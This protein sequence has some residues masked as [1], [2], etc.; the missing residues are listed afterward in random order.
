MVAWV[1]DVGRL[2]SPLFR[3]NETSHRAL[4]IKDAADSTASN[5]RAAQIARSHREFTAKIS[6]ALEEADEAVGFLELSH[7]EGILKGDEFLR[8]LDE[9]QQI[10]RILAKSRETAQSNEGK[11]RKGRKP[12]SRR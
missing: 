3:V 6:I 12:R 5:Y 10:T 9:G 2:I 11:S 8:I 1:V 7:R 4:Q